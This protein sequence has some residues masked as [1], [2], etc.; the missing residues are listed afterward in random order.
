MSWGASPA[1]A[2]GTIEGYIP[3]RPFRLHSPSATAKIDAQPSAARRVAVLMP[4]L[5]AG[6][7]FDAV[8]R[9][10]ADQQPALQRLAIIDSGSSDGTVAK[11]QA[12]GLTVCPIAPSTFNHGATRQMAIEQL[13]GDAAFVVFLTQDAV[14]AN[15][16]AITCLLGAFDDS[17]VAAAYGRQ[18]PHA[19]ATPVAAHARLFNYPPQ[20]ATRTLADADR[21]G[22][23]ACFLSNSFA[24]YRVSALQQVGGFAPGLILGEDMHLA[25]RLMLA[26]HAVRYQGDAIVYHSHN[27]SCLQEFQRYFDTVFSMPNKTGC[28]GTL[29]APAVKDGNSWF[30][31]WA[32]CCNM[33]SGVCQRLVSAPC[34]S[35]LPTG[36]GAATTA[37]P[38][39]G[40]VRFPCTKGSGHER[41]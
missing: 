28:C 6:P 23:K 24:A 13:A 7:R 5:D 27:Y 14:L 26:G 2:E 36:W 40:S 39:P 8:L 16:Q 19:D 38:V 1:C 30:L 20:S 41:A 12:A 31:K 9:A 33:H 4:T 3:S 29:V 15:P 32:I 11:A 22:L 21:L 37:C 25:A 35:C 17:S 34:S 10:L 18:L